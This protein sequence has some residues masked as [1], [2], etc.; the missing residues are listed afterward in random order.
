[1]TSRATTKKSVKKEKPLIVECPEC[2]GHG[3]VQARCDWCNKPLTEENAAP[4]ADDICAECMSKNGEVP[5]LPHP[6]GGY[7]EFGC[8][9][10]GCKP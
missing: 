10:P 6:N 1:M 9:C 4:G 2:S 5:D 8:R 3:K 7:A